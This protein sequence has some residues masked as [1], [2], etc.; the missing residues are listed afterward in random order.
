MFVYSWNDFLHLYF[1]WQ[2]ESVWPCRGIQQDGEIVDAGT[3]SIIASSTQKAPNS[4]IA[5]LM[6]C[7][8]TYVWS[9]NPSFFFPFCTDAHQ[10][11][12]AESCSS[13]S[14]IWEYSILINSCFAVHV[15]IN[16]TTIGSQSRS[17]NYPPIKFT[18]FLFI[19]HQTAQTGMTQGRF[20]LPKN[21]FFPSSI[22]LLLRNPMNTTRTD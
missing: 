4:K 8:S 10:V 11:S 14:A 21:C 1:A 20:G 3:M 18:F 7:P 19:N 6:S 15:Q 2:E 5:S 9:S 12:V 22:P 16:R 13:S 17:C